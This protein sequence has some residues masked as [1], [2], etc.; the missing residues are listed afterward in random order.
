MGL[1]LK[2]VKND[3]K[4]GIIIMIILIPDYNFLFFDCFRKLKKGLQDD[5]V[6]DD[7]SLRFCH[8]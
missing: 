4:I 3:S 6:K 8:R 5:D 1:A 7:E 2:M